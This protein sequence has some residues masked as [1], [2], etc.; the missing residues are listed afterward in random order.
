MKR[1]ELNDLRGKTAQELEKIVLGKKL[2][3]EK[4]RMKI[5]GGKEKNLKVRKNL[6]R[7]IAKILTLIREKEIIESLEAK[8]E[9][10]KK[11]EKNK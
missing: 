2:E 1:K 11:V 7:E 10:G 3:I 8:N 5:I 4:A 6:A 9:E